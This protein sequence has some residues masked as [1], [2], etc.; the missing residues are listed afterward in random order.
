MLKVTYWCRLS[1]MRA[2][3]CYPA[4]DPQES[5]LVL[6]FNLGRKKA[7]TKANA[8]IQMSNLVHLY[9]KF[10]QWTNYVLWEDFFTA[11]LVQMAS[12]HLLLNE[13]KI[14]KRTKFA[15]KSKPPR[16]VLS[17]GERLKVYLMYGC[18]LQSSVVL[19]FGCK[20]RRSQKMTP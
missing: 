4:W 11:I 15:I 3:W 12:E 1:C 18:I 6:I 9:S 5:L 8:I 20:T 17:Y 7:K 19:S 2:L 14:G 16:P 13:K 10:I